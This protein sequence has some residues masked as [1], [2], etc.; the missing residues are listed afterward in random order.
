MHCTGLYWIWKG[1]YRVKKRW[2]ISPPKI[3]VNT[4]I[5]G[6]SLFLLGTD[7]EYQGIFSSSMW[8]SWTNNCH[9][10]TYEIFLTYFLAF[11]RENQK[12]NL[13]FFVWPLFSCCFTSNLV[14]H[15]RFNLLL[16]SFVWY[17][18]LSVCN[19]QERCY[20]CCCR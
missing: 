12:E 13:F 5:L 14:F 20:C 19:S 17:C 10:C 4:K 9:G 18:S 2:A 11:D 16:F 7:T 6:I 8:I 1:F 3:S 15:F